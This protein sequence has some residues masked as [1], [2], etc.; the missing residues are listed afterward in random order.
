MHSDY[1]NPG[2]VI[3]T[4]LFRRQMQLLRQYF[5]PVG[6]EDIYRWTSGKDDLPPRSV[7]V[8]FDDGFEDNYTMAAPVMEEFDIRGTF[9]LAAHAVEFQ[10]L[11]W[12][13]KIHY[14][15]EHWKRSGQVIEELD[16][17]DGNDSSEVKTRWRTDD[18]LEYDRAYRRF[19]YPCAKVT[20][21]GQDQRIADLENRLG[22][23]YDPARAP[24]MMSWSMAEE[25]TRRGHVIG[26]HTYSHP[27]VAHLS[28]EDQQSEIARSTELFRRRMQTP[29]EHF[30]YPHP[31]LE[32]QWD[33]ASQ[34]LINASGYK[35]IVLTDPGWITQQTPPIQLPRITIGNWEPDV[36]LWKIETALAGIKT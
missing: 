28:P 24:R 1:I 33:K 16:R 19:G 10:T 12:F 5:N 17:Q 30:S 18:P 21:E 2:I 6:I 23:Q 22:I 14:L 11:P 29:V 9:Y 15:F 26:N 20:V 13:C 3:E 36:F 27:N 35:T 7:A 25:L 8:T 34:A 32:P 4:E 31:C